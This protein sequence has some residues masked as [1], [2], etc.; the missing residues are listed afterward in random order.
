MQ[1]E[2]VQSILVDV[3]RNKLHN[4]KLNKNLDFNKYLGTGTATLSA[5]LQRLLESRSLWES[6]WIDDILIKDIRVH[7]NEV[8]IWGDVIYGKFNTTKEWVSPLLFQI[9]F[10][11]DWRDFIAYTYYFDIKDKEEIEY[12]S[13]R[14]N[15]N[16]WDISFDQKYSSKI[17]WKYI[18]Y[19][20]KD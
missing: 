10:N 4:K 11:A 16:T 7:S 20:N 15:R 3:L 5:I 18:I 13:Y 8:Y 1:I 12:I 2:E 14:K 19:I 9:S 6:N 17:K